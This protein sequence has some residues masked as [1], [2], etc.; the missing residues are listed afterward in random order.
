MLPKERYFNIITNELIS[1]TPEGIRLRTKATVFLVWE[2]RL[3]WPQ[4]AEPIKVLE[5]C[6]IFEML[7]A[8]A[9]RKGKLPV[10]II[11]IILCGKAIVNS[12]VYFFKSVLWNPYCGNFYHCRKNS[13]LSIFRMYLVILKIRSKQWLESDLSHWRKDVRNWNKGCKLG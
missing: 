1:R 11:I 8:L 6:T 5:Y 7:S 9:Q 12:W 3:F 2:L 13:I 10:Y 4:I